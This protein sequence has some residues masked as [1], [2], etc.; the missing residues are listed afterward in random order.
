MPSYVK[1]APS[2]EDVA[3]IKSDVSVCFRAAG[4]SRLVGPETSAVYPKID[5]AAQECLEVL[6]G[7]SGQ[8]VTRNTGTQGGGA[9]TGTITGGLA[10]ATGIGSTTGAGSGAADAVTI[11]V[12]GAGVTGSGATVAAG[13]AADAMTAGNGALSSTIGAP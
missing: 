8:V 3:P 4:I 12:A 7:E 11:G 10:V 2:F 1:A 6:H 9:T 13:A 5:V